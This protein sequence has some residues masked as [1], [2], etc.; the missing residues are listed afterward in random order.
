MMTSRVAIDATLL[1]TNCQA[2]SVPSEL[3]GALFELMNKNG[4]DNDLETMCTRVSINGPSF[5]IMT[6]EEA[7]TTLDFHAR[8]QSCVAIRRNSNVA[9]PSIAWHVENMEITLL[10]DEEEKSD[11]DDDDASEPKC[12]GKVCFCKGATSMTVDRCDGKEPYFMLLEQE[13]TERMVEILQFVRPGTSKTTLNVM[14][15]TQFSERS[16]PVRSA[17]PTPSFSIPPWFGHCVAVWLSAVVRIH[18]LYNSRFQAGIE[19]PLCIDNCFLTRSD[20]VF[21]LSM[22]LHASTCTCWCGKGSKG[23]PAVRIVFDQNNIISFKAVCKHVDCSTANFEVDFLRRHAVQTDVFL[24]CLCKTA[25]KLI[26]S[27]YN[28]KDLS[29]ELHAAFLESLEASRTLVSSEQLKLNDIIA[30]TMLRSGIYRRKRKYN[31]SRCE[32]LDVRRTDSIPLK[33]FEK[34]TLSTHEHLF[35]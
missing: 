30:E 18:V 9:M 16:K 33:T 23:K 10:C 32:I 2:V 13:D 4:M 28:D 26:D 35:N 15:H 24:S 17:N 34:T 29:S 14:A 31:R 3:R 11:D 7:D 21:I 27:E 8:W 25:M 22:P 1:K 5:A 6:L 12:I 19:R 20:E